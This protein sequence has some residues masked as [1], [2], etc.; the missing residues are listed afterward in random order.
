[1]CIRDSYNNLPVRKNETKSVVTKA[2][3]FDVIYVAIITVCVHSFRFGYVIEY[4]GQWQK[5]INADCKQAQNE[6][7]GEWKHVDTDNR[8]K[9]IKGKTLFRHKTMINFILQKHFIL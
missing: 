1:M 4:N 9:C 3:N 5:S 2:L 6:D 8:V 7:T